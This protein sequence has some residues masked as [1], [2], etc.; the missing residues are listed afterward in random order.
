MRQRAVARDLLKLA[1]AIA[2]TSCAVSD[3]T[4]YY[5]LDQIHRE[6]G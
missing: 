1:A 6:A 4:Q 5:T 2:L 3:T